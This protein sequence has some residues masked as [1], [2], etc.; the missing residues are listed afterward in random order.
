MFIKNKIKFNLDE[1]GNNRTV[2]FPTY[3]FDY[4]KTKSNM[5]FITNIALNRNDFIRTKHPIYSFAVFGKFSQSFYNLNNTEAFSE[6]SPF[7]LLHKLKAKMLLIDIDYQ[8]SFTFVHYVEQFNNIEYRFHKYLNKHKK[9]YSIFVR[10]EKIITNV[11][12]IGKILEQNNVS[13]GYTII[14]LKKAFNTITKDIKEN[15][16]KNLYILDNT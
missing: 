15:F 7:G 14:N 5:G 13:K 3:N 2:L 9:T 12:P 16:G 4:Y 6:K 8:N 11:N 10:K 1:V